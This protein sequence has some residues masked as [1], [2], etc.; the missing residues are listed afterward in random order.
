MFITSTLIMLHAS[1]IQKYPKMGF[2]IIST[3]FLWCI[4]TYSLTFFLMMVSKNSKGNCFQNM[5]RYH[6]FFSL[7]HHIISLLTA[8]IPF[9]EI[10]SFYSLVKYHY[11]HLRYLVEN[12]RITEINDLLHFRFHQKDN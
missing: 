3:V 7:S 12:G 2:Y 10:L 4:A 8:S 1:F 11:H 9:F 6:A 5:H